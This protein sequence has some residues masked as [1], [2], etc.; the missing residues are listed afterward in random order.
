MHAAAGEGIGGHAVSLGGIRDQRA[1]A[2]E[3]LAVILNDYF[4]ALA[5]A[6]EVQGGALATMQGDGALL[7][8]GDDD[9]SRR[10]A[11]LA[12]AELV[13][14]LPDLLAK[15]SARWHGDGYLVRLAVRAGIASGFCSLGDWGGERLEF[16]IIGT[17][18]NLAS[19]LQAQA[20]ASSVLVSAVTAEL[21]RPQIPRNVG[22]A[23]LIRLKSLGAVTAYPLVDLPNLSANVPAA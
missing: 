22:Q 10:R 12:C 11:A 9:R 17:P 8:F 16:T 4:G 5:R 1:V 14:G 6:T 2:A 15:L 21:L 18:V 19:R 20:A 3:A 13:A 23:K 7:Y